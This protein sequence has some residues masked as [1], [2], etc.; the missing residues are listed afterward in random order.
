MAK[1]NYLRPNIL[2][3]PYQREVFEYWDRGGTRAVECW[4]RRTGKDLTY[5]SVAFMKMRE[6]KGLYVH[7]LPEAEHARRTIWD[8]FTNEGDRLID[9]AFPKDSRTKTLDHDMRIEFKNGCAWQLGGSDQYD[10][11]VGSNPIA[12]TYSEFALAHPRGWDLMRPILKINGGW[13]AF[14]STPRG[15]N[16]M[17]TMLQLAKENPDWRWSHLSALEARLDD[18]SPVMTQHDID[19]EIRQGMPEELARQEYLCDFSAANVGAILGR[20]VERADKEGRLLDTVYDAAGE[21]IDVSCDLGFRDTAAFW[22][23]QRWHDAHG[24]VD[25]DEDNGLDA[26][27]WIQRLSDKP[28]SYGTIYLPH[29]GRAKTFQTRHTV[30]EQFA[31][32]IKSGRL[33]AQRAEIVPQTSI[34]DRVNAARSIMPYCRFDRV[35]CAQGLLTLREWQ[36]KYDEE[37]KTF[38]RE[39]DHNWASHGGDAFSYGAQKMRFSSKSLTIK[40]EL[41]PKNWAESRDPR[42]L[43]RPTLADMWAERE[44]ELSQRSRIP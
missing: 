9:V 23:W 22:F 21:R 2:P 1:P 19:E 18:G 32:A 42:H 38:S 6:R 43:Q 11:W 44:H 25:Y 5:M 29:D 17:H 4:A 10:R 13:A 26:E 20:Q 36:Y 8:G 40:R 41:G 39:P 33:N 31:E 30:V 27:Q 37:R 12:I 14:I 24:L 28:W 15:Y 16:H 3:R 35:A 34:S 7:F